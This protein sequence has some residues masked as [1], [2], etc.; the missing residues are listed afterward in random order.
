[1]MRASLA[2]SVLLLTLSGCTSMPTSMESTPVPEDRFL[3]TTG[4]EDNSAAE[5]IV[6]R[7]RSFSGSACYYAIHI[8]GQLAARIAPS[9]RAVFKLKPGK[10]QLKV[11]RDSKGSGLCSLGDD[12]TEKIV[13]LDNSEKKYFRLSMS[14]SGWPHLD[15]IQNPSK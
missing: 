3:F 12:V 9:E 4:S 5:V 2:F 8:D 6:I 13:T 7:D 1:M 10:A 11:T 14:I 15:Q